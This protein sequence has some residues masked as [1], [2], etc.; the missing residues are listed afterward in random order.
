MLRVSQAIITWYSPMVVSTSAGAEQQHNAKC[1]RPTTSVFRT[2]LWFR[3]SHPRPLRSTLCAHNLPY[4]CLLAVAHHCIRRAGGVDRAALKRTPVCGTVLVGFIATTILPNNDFRRG[5]QHILRHS[6]C[7]SLHVRF[8]SV[9]LRLTSAADAVAQ[10]AI[11]SPPNFIAAAVAL[12]R[13]YLFGVC[14]LTSQPLQPLMQLPTR[15]QSRLPIPL[16]SPLPF[17]APTGPS[18]H[19]P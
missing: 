17:H 8:I 13:P 1:L 10:T 5:C 6:V 16:P 18:T 4:V 9:K 19:H 2:T 7:V 11:G 15:P 14:A 12:Q 3:C